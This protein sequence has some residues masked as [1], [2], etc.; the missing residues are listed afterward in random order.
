MSI[1]FT[2]ISKLTSREKDAVS[3]WK[4]K[5]KKITLKASEAEA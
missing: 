5:N 3:L 4:I 1:L 2:Q